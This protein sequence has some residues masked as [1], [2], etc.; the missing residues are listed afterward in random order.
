M[1]K[2]TLP[3][4]DA[5]RDALIQRARQG[6]DE[7]LAAL[8]WVYPEIDMDSKG[9][10]YLEV[11][12][13]QKQ[14]VKDLGG[15]WS[16]DAGKWFIPAHIDS[17]DAFERW[18]HRPRQRIYL[19]VPFWEKDDC[20]R[21]GGRFDNDLKLWYIPPK[22]HFPE[23]FD[24]WLPGYSCARA[25]PPETLPAKMAAYYLSVLGHHDI[26][27]M[28]D[29]AKT[30]FLDDI[31]FDELE[32]GQLHRAASLLEEFWKASR[33]RH[34][35]APYPLRPVRGVNPAIAE[36]LAGVV[37]V[38]G[39]VHNK[40]RQ[41]LLALP[42]L[43]SEEGALVAA[44]LRLPIIN[45]AYFEPQDRPRRPVVGTHC[46]LDEAMADL[47]DWTE[48]RP[49]EEAWRATETLFQAVNE[50]HSTLREFAP[51]DAKPP[52]LWLVAHDRHDE[53]VVHLMAL[54][55]QLSYEQAAVPP[56]YAGLCEGVE[57]Q[58]SL[59]LERQRR[60]GLR[61]T[62]HMSAVFGLDPSQREALRHFL[63]TPTGSPLALSGPPGTG[64]TACLQGVIATTL[65]NVTLAT[66]AS[67]HPRAP[68]IIACSATNQAVTNI[69]SSFGD[70]SASGERWLAP[71]NAYGWYFASQSA[72]S[73]SEF[74]R[75]QILRRGE[76]G[77]WEYSGRAESLDE[78]VGDA[79][80]LRA[81]E[82]EYLRAF[83]ENFPDAK[84]VSQ[85]DDAAFFLLSTLWTL[86]EGYSDVEKTRLDMTLP[87]A[88]ESL[89]RLSALVGEGGLTKRRAAR[90]RLDK[91]RRRDQ[92]L[93]RRQSTLEEAVSRLTKQQRR[94]LDL[95]RPVR[96]MNDPGP[97]PRW[98]SALI[99]WFTRRR[100]RALRGALLDELE[101]VIGLAAPPE[102]GGD[103]ALLEAADTALASLRAQTERAEHELNRFQSRRSIINE[104][105]QRWHA[106][107]RSQAG[108]LEAM[109]SLIAY[110]REM[111]STF[112]PEAM[113]AAWNAGLDAGLVGVDA[114][115]NADAQHGAHVGAALSAGGELEASTTFDC[116]DQLLDRTIRRR[117]FELA[118]R[119][120]EARWLIDTA[121]LLA[122]GRTER[123]EE[124]LRRQCMLAP[125]IVATVHLMPSLFR[126]ERNSAFLAL[127]LADLLII[128][129]AGQA[130]PAISLG[131]FS[132][133]QRAIVVGDVE[134]LKPIW[135]VRDAEDLGLLRQSDLEEQ[136]AELDQRGLRAST[137]SAMA[138]AQGASAFSAG[139]GRGITLL[140]HYR[141]RPTII[142]FCNRLVYDRLRP[143]IPVRE[144][145]PGRLFHP[146]TY[147]ECG[148]GR[149]SRERGSLVNRE[150]ANELI[151]WLV[152]N[153]P[154]IEGHYNH[155][156][157]RRLFPGDEGYRDI[158]D[159]V[160]IVTPFVQHT[161]YLKDTLERQLLDAGYADAQA[162]AGR[163][164]LGTVHRLQGAERPL[165]LFSST[166]TPDDGATP[167]M[168]ANRDMLNVAV[169]RAQDHFILFGHPELFFSPKAQAPDNQAPSAVLGRYMKTH[170][171]RLYPR[172]L[173]VVESPGKVAPLQDALGKDC[174]VEA[175]SGH[176]RDIDKLDANTGRVSW[177]VAAEKQSM[178]FTIA[179]ALKEMDELVLA[180]D[181]DREGEAIGWHLLDELR[182]H[183]P[184][185][186][187][188][189]SRMV[190]HEITPAALIEGFRNR[191][192]WT[193]SNR[194]E[195][196]IARAII[197][198]AIGEVMTGE[199][200]KRL[201][202]KGQ[203]LRSGIGRVRIALLRLIAE[204]DTT[205]RQV[206]EE[207]WAVSVRT[208]HQ[209]FDLD[210]W[211]TE[212]EAL[213]A[214]VK[215]F[216]SQKARRIK[217]AIAMADTL[218]PQLERKG[219]WLGPATP[220]GTLE[221]LI[222][223]Y[224]Q[225]GLRPIDTYRI[226][227]EL[228][229]G[230][231]RAV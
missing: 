173:V 55:R 193:H 32:N 146:M 115:M 230:N 116:L 227:Q 91:K 24:I 149:A 181:D 7:A 142:E 127:G 182:E 25:K 88:V 139:D 76:R 27:K 93:S 81:L 10:I 57:S 133:A 221:I 83:R 33:A 170:G 9:D 190:F 65:V 71:V 194:A 168:D 110:F 231:R 2:P 67:E 192:P 128:D 215:R 201:Q 140:R 172:K 77:G 41:V 54:Y 108:G 158:G 178:L 167:F 143:L 26:D 103:A 123:H 222:A 80:A 101:P 16:A 75:F 136:A 79:E 141:C 147:V 212:S 92:R 223:A 59:P 34:D 56:L 1:N 78:L 96:D 151:D 211:V 61:H 98:F 148:D 154:N 122:K 12:Y 135:S 155:T 87:A 220:A 74:E 100:R 218:V 226:L 30:P 73:K 208:R 132:L 162:I 171:Q 117:C 47:M 174:R 179:A 207:S 197:D 85:I 137:G 189:T 102:A 129:E 176:F 138:A 152:D 35:K 156:A 131:L 107:A 188:I 112:L 23:Q 52:A 69:I 31:T 164:K 198:K 68:L 150:E 200:G 4:A 228:Y 125:V 175:T 63:A 22:H 217:Q 94:L 14:E 51:Q 43:L 204:H 37:V 205:A 72:A 105:E 144:E 109:E 66:D 121:S 95:A 104:A 111:A 15:R 113:A 183:C 46:A 209:T 89:S 199:V 29:I 11:P 114:A 225:F 134:Q 28:G 17:I 99:A 53:A 196:A 64:K 84:G 213:D 90:R 39:W 58:P 19:N 97:G 13:S 187:L 45:P 62:G 203:Q 120:W 224:E 50:K 219:Y 70:V 60:L 177:R 124:S 186:G 38:V 160:G 161:N 210:F 157:S 206:P 49:W 3:P 202:A 163:M 5:H 145:D 40:H 20:I 185:D 166:N 82:G 8:G 216:S 21:M 42:A 36:Q 118:A 195:A 119:Y 6:D 159:L 184:L 126:T 191:V 86:A 48:D 18:L 214:P 165:V 229:E 153:R 130:D 106:P 180:T 44:Q 169:S